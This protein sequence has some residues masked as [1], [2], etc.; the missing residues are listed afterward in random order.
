MDIRNAALTLASEHDSFYIYDE[1]TIDRQT[2]RL[3]RDFPG[4]RFLYSIKAN[5]AR[6]VVRSV[7]SHGFGADAASLRETV[8]ARELGLSPDLIHYSAP[9]KRRAD[10]SAALGAAT[11]VADSLGE[12][13]L[14][15]ALA[16]ETG[17]P[18]KIGVRLNPDFG[19]DGGPGGPSKFGVDLGQALSF[20]KGGGLPPGVRISGIHVHLKSQVLD[21]A[22]LERYYENMF[23]LADEFQT[24]L[25]SPLNFVNL[26]S[27]MG[28]PGAPDGQGFDTAAL[29]VRTAELA[30]RFSDR[31]GGAQ[32]IIETGRFAV[33]Q[34][35]CYVTKVADRKESM[36]KTY[37]ILNG[38][39]NGFLRPCL[40][41]L[42]RRCAPGGGPGGCEPFYSGP[43]SFRFL[44]LS[45][46]AETETVTLAGN[47]CTAADVAAEDIVLPRLEPGD[48][49]A[50]TNA[51]CYGA[52][53]TPMG[54]SSQEPPAE[55]FLGRDGRVSDA[56]K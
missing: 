42:V 17:A 15:G 31:L 46:S 30:A 53:L 5:P 41:Q 21:E 56:A 19:F 8:L 16:E 37:V 43:D 20:V 34:S 13:R 55:F 24:A 29:G 40:A 6:A 22:A 3:T 11:V 23:R 36:G 52:S 51:G 35:G 39:L 33:G 12:L 48:L 54:F 26:G 10:I 47:L 9:G 28:I 50:I 25:G 44:A 45:G 32:I 38:T 18:A 1:D 7:L 4:V 2:E 49:V 27:G 14:I